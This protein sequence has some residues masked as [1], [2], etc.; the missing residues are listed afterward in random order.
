MRLSDIMS[1]SNLSLYP[2]IALVLFLVAFAAVVRRTY[3]RRWKDTL[4]RAGSMAL[5][6][7]AIE[8][9]AS[10]PPVRTPPASTLVV[11]QVTTTTPSRKG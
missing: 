8:T 9:P 1:A 11:A 4:D 6:D 3:S 10:T 2:K 7:G 5:D